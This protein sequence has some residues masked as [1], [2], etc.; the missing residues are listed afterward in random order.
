MNSGSWSAWQ[1]AAEPPDPP[2][3]CEHGVPEDV[4]CAHCIEKRLRQEEEAFAECEAELEE[5]LRARDRAE[6]ERDALREWKARAV[7]VLKMVEYVNESCG[8]C[9]I[10]ARGQFGGGHAPD[11]ALAALLK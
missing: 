8:L 11:C 2:E 5:S 10:C 3:D 6:K 4:K 1:A 9:P 7:E